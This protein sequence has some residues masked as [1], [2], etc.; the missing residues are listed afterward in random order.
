MECWPVR[1]GAPGAGCDPGPRSGV[2]PPL[3]EARV[4]EHHAPVGA[5][6]HN[7]KDEDLSFHLVREHHAPVGALRPDGAHDCDVRRRSGSTTHL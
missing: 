6:R 1:R 7:E 3:S 2:I 4:R 5:L